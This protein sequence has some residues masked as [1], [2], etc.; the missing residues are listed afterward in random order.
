MFTER[1]EA[2]SE[3]RTRNLTIDAKNVCLCFHVN[4]LNRTQQAR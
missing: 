1:W 3:H 2:V 4:F